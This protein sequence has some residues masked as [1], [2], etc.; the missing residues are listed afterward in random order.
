MNRD[1]KEKRVTRS[2]TEMCC[3]VTIRDNYNVKISPSNVVTIR[4]KKFCGQIGR[5]V[6][7]ACFSPG[8]A[9][10]IIIDVR[11]IEL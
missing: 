1:H 2:E 11:V 8:M 7:T 10:P 3:F 9:S 5:Q 6:D 4:A